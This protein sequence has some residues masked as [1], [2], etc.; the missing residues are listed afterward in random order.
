MDSLEVALCL[1]E[2]AQTILIILRKKESASFLQEAIDK[3]MESPKIYPYPDENWD[4]L[5]V[6][7]ETIPLSDRAL[8][9]GE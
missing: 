6:G 7:F 5:R 3:A 1:M 4:I 2:K 8:R 9:L